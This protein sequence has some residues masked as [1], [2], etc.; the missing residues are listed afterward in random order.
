VLPIA[1][2]AV[3]AALI[4]GTLSSSSTGSA[5][6]AADTSGLP[7]AEVPA[8]LPDTSAAPPATAKCAGK[9]CTITF[10]AEGSSV[11]ALGTTI[12]ATK[13]Y[14]DG[15]TVNVAGADLVTNLKTAAKGGGY[16]VKAVSVQSGAQSPHVVKLTKK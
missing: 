9:V 8:A 1:G 16:T 4:F 5:S 3:A 6:G 2:A 10:P 7:A 13:F 11:Q 12:S 14:V 15:I